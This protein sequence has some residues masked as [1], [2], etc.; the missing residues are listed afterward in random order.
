[1]PT[2]ALLHKRRHR[3]NTVNAVAVERCEHVE[4]RRQRRI[5]QA[6]RTLRRAPPRR[7]TAP[8]RQRR[9]EPAYTKHSSRSPQSCDLAQLLV[10]DRYSMNRPIRHLGQPGHTAAPVKGF[11]VPRNMSRECHDHEV[12]IESHPSSSTKS[13]LR[14]PLFGTHSP[15]NLLSPG[16]LFGKPP[17]PRRHGTVSSSTASMRPRLKPPAHARPR[18]QRWHKPRLSRR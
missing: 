5:Y 13:A 16:T 11:V 8:P 18:R 2:S 1:M 6:L 12:G 4:S 9:A 15:P 10:P 7:R 3:H 17:P 14:S